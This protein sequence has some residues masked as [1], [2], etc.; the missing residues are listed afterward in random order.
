MEYLHRR[1]L[2]RRARTVTGGIKGGSREIPYL[3]VVAKF[4]ARGPLFIPSSPDLRRPGGLRSNR[5]GARPLR[6]RDFG[7]F[8]PGLG[9]MAG[10]FAHIPGLGPFRLGNLIRSGRH[11]HENRAASEGKPPQTGTRLQARIKEHHVQRARGQQH[12]HQYD[13]QPVAGEFENQP[14]DV[15]M[16]ERVRARV[17]SDIFDPDGR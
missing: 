3:A 17:L 2:L 12:E 7:G 13:L 6:K 10:L 11:G 14:H 8:R 4:Q 15:R 1:S 16:M 5:T 9:A